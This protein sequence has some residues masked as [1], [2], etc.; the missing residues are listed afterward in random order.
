MVRV[1]AKKQAQAGRH[2]VHRTSNQASTG[3]QAHVAITVSNR[4]GPV[5]CVCVCV[6][7]CALAL[8]LR[9]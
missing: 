6:E 5:V 8:G 3:R 7:G 9:V 4:Q 1:R 2:V